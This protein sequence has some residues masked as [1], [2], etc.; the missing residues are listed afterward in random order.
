MA[1]R[2]RI[3][4]KRGPP[5]DAEQPF[6]IEGLNRLSLGGLVELFST[7]QPLPEAM[8]A[9]FYRAAFVGPWWLRVG[10]PPS[11]HLGGLPGWQG[12]KFL[13]A[14][15]ATN[16]LLRGGKRVEALT[17]H[18]KPCKSKVDGRTSIALHYPHA[19]PLP[20]RWVT[21]ELRMLDSRTILAVTV[22]HKPLVERLRFPFLLTHE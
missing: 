8:R 11:V 10:G 7:L 19:A 22:V 15:R 9:G 6:D 5:R 16:I 21:D 12:K 2:P 1:T 17:M 4:Q 13:D 18:C 3:A 14:E 20:W